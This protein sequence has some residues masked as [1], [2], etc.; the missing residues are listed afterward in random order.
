VCIS[1]SINGQYQQVCVPS[2]SY[3][4]YILYRLHLFCNSLSLYLF[5]FNFVN[6]VVIEGGVQ[7]DTITRHVEE[8]LKSSIKRKM[9]NVQNIEI[10]TSDVKSHLCVFINADYPFFYGE[11]QFQGM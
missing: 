8:H 1:L 3:V 7:F 6:G 2:Q 11:P 5:Q 4:G 9:K 10:Q